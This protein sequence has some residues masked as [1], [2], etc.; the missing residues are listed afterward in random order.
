MSVEK[1]A[2]AA[3][4]VLGFAACAPEATCQ[5]PPEAELVAPVSDVVL[6]IIPKAVEAGSQA[7]LSMNSPRFPSD[8]AI[9]GA[10]AAWQCWAGVA[11]IDTHQLVKDRFGPNHQPAALE[12]EPG[13]TTTIPAVGLL[14]ADRHSIAIPDV[15]PGIYR[16]RDEVWFGSEPQHVYVFV[17]VR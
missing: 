9:T 17:E 2:A 16:V 7:E 13:V 3:F 12:V 6:T 11:W 4:L 14:V 10:G 5:E 8:D 1:A 15:A